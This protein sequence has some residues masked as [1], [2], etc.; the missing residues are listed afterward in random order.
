ILFLLMT[1]PQ[2]VEMQRL[3]VEPPGAR[4]RTRERPC[5]RR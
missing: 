4:D 1:L 2:L 5:K 3:R